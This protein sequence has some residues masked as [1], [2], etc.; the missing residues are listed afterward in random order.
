MAEWFG[1]PSTVGAQAGVRVV[2]KQEPFSM[3]I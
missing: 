3:K 1:F 2:A